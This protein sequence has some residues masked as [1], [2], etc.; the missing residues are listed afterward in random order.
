V[1]LAA[2]ETRADETEVSDLDPEAKR[3]VRVLLAEDNAVNQKVATKILH[4]LGFFCAVAGDGEQAVARFVEH[5]ERGEPFDV[6][7][8]D[9][10]MPVMDGVEAARAILGR[11]VGEVGAAKPKIFALTADVAAS[12]IQE[13]RDAGMDGFLGKPIDRVRLGRVMRDVT[14]WVAKGR[15]E[16]FHAER[17]WEVA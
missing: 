13:C 9:L 4:A 7:L 3:R 10:Q 11:E 17:T 14:K 1:N 5:A 8:M 12:V 6:V 2:L 15:P 16:A